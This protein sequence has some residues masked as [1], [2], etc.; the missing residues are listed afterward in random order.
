MYLS[1]MYAVVLL[2]AWKLASLHVYVVLFV[3]FPKKIDKKQ[4][5]KKKKEQSLEIWREMS[6]GELHA[7]D[8]YMLLSLD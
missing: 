5:P 7:E 4:Q 6:V 8:F 1:V 3:C 2:W